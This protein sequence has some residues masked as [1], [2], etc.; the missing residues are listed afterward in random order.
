M[1]ILQ[2]VTV[3]FFAPRGTSFSALQRTQVLASLGHSIEILAYPL[4]EDVHLEGVRIHRVPRIPGVR[5][6]PMGPSFKK[7]ILDLLLTLK[8]AWWL[9][10][11]GP[12]DAVH[13]HE[14]AAFWVAM[15][16]PLHRGPVLYDMHSSLV[17]Q[18]S[19]FGY[20]ESGWLHRIMAAFE[21]RALKRATGVIII[22]PELEGVVR[23]HA[24]EVPVQLIE[25]LPVTWDLPKPTEEEMDALRRRFGLQAHRTILYTGTFGRN[26][27]LDLAIE[28]M[29]RVSDAIPRVRLM[30]VGGTGEDFRRLRDLVRARGVEPVVTLAG[31][32]PYRD[33]PA[34]MEI[35]DVLLSPRTSGTNTPLKIYTYLAAG[36]PIVATDLRTHTQVLS[37]ET[38]RLVEPRAGAIA[39]G[40]I[41]LLSDPE[42]SEALARAAK[43]VA[44]RRYG[45]DAYTEQVERILERSRLPV[46][47][48][49]TP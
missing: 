6:I 42:R 40:I 9:G 47:A 43:S 33:M 8:T 45:I 31:P 34:L 36:K 25:N 11:R 12:W 48:E 21:I 4:G 24:P 28:A 37:E 13:V 17:E 22:C 23:R 14:E 32:Q 20:S 19:N 44:E 16:K 5:S 2:I 18:L 38:A 35:A 46:R 10:V 29:T 30:L 41:D 39:D 1:R 49:R 26:Q 27:G 3:P 7:L 15:M